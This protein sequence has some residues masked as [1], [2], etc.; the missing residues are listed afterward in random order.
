MPLLRSRPEPA[1]LGALVV[2]ASP[3]LRHRRDHAVAKR[4]RQVLLFAA[5]FGS[6]CAFAVVAR[7]EP[8][9]FEAGGRLGYAL[10]L[11]E[12]ESGTDLSELTPG[13]VPLW[14]D[15]GVRLSP[16]ISIASYLEVGAGIPGRVLA[17]DCDAYEALGTSCDA[18]TG[19]LRIGI[20]SQLHLAPG[21][22]ID[23]W[24]GLTAGYEWMAFELELEQSDDASELNRG[25]HGFELGLQGGADFRISSRA[26]LGPFAGLTF[27]R[28]HSYVAE[29]D[30]ECGVVSRSSGEIAEPSLHGALVL[31]VRVVVLP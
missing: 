12:L 27:G 18:E 28:Y 1:I 6:T 15:L 9:R 17:R 31:G 8:P 19:A 10:H 16:A 26:G 23:P 29:C 30:G 7:A 2:N 14:V 22:A 11:G 3:E 13:R 20:Q 25:V 24:V 5:A 21:A 4:A